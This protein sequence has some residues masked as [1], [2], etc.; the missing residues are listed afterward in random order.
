MK[1][2][3]CLPTETEAMGGNTANGTEVLRLARLAED[4]GFDSAWVVD[5][6]CYSAAA[7]MEALGATAPPDLVGKIYGAWECL[8]MCAALA[9]ETRHME[10]GTLVINTG[11]RN[12][13]LLARMSETIDELSAGR[14][15]LG[16][17]AGDFFTEHDT[18]G[19]PWE[20]RVSRFEEALQIIRPMLAGEHVTFDGEFY[21]TQG[22]VNLP[23]GPR[24]DGLPLLI[25]VLGRGPRMKRLVA[26]YADQWN[27]WMGSGDSHASAYIKIRDDMLAA[28][29]EHGRDPESLVRHVTPRISPTGVAPT[30]PD[31]N[32]LSGTAEEIAE[33]LHAF[34]DLGVNHIS[35]WPHPN[36]EEGIVAL[37]RV[38]EHFRS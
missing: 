36:N 18:F 28:C 23:R 5:H 21:S 3:I 19:Y 8:T 4:A 27:C 31:M 7:E 32:P 2:G 38:L 16:V 11:Y 1:I 26:Q 34:K 12:P 10:I 20:R 37:A 25:G 15:I 9:R 33:A 17:G 24:P 35:A 30:S 13:A 29:E 14:F 6:F 22:A